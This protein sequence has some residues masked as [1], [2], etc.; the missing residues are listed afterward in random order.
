MTH[1][2]NIKDAAAAHAFI[3][4]GKARFTL[5]SN[6]T[7]KRYTYRV[8]AKKNSGTMYFVSLLTGADNNMDYEYIGYFVT[9][10]THSVLIA[11][12]RGA[13]NHPA[14]LGLSWFVRSIEQS[15]PLA[16]PDVVEF[17]HEGRC[18]RCARPLT[19]PVSIERGLGPECATKGLLT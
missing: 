17:W 1:P 8:T 10:S 9:G 13:P 4:G 18:A 7:D 19:D 11:G 16:I 6:K 2:H 3:F 15:N 14:F 5:V 12:Q